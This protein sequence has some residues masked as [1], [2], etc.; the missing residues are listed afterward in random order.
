MGQY[1]ATSFHLIEFGLGLGLD[2]GLGLGLGLG[3][4]S[5][6]YPLPSHSGDRQERINQ[7]D[8]QDQA[9]E[10]LPRIDSP[11]SPSQSPV[12]GLK[13]RIGVEA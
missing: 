12:K 6:T 5:L 11:T 1:L 2:S 9:I 13:L 8:V 4:G 10:I 7:D 3:L